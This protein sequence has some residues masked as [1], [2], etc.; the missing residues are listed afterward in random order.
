M[1]SKSFLLAASEE[2]RGRI[3]RYQEFYEGSR[4]ARGL[5]VY[6]MMK[7]WYCESGDS[8]MKVINEVAMSDE[9]KEYLMSGPCVICKHAYLFSMMQAHLDELR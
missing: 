2:A 5:S 3:Q 6:P 7:S 1:E 8:I 9:A 4:A